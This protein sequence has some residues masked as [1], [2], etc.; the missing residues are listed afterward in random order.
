MYELAS[1]GPIKP[2]VTSQPLVYNLRCL[3]F[4][5]PNITLEMTCIHENFDFIV[6]LVR[7]MGQRLKTD[8]VCSKVMQKSTEKL[9]I[10]PHTQLY[11]SDSMRSLRS[12]FC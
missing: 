1:K 7:E 5:P 2:T 8:A 3:K 4:S 6:D 12:F 10:Q 9:H 11:L